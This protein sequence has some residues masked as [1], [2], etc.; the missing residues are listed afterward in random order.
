MRTV[1]LAFFV[2]L[3]ALSNIAY[4]QTQDDALA[5]IDKAG[6]HMQEMLAMNFSVAR[7]NDTLTEANYLFEAQELINRSGGKPDFSLIMKKADEIEQTRKYALNAYDE[8]VA[9]EKMVSGMSGANSTLIE[10]YLAEA[11]DAFANERYEEARSKI[12]ETYEKVSEQQALST[13]LATALEASRKNIVAF[14]GS[15][16]PGLTAGSAAFVVFVLFFGNRVYRV[17]VKRKMGMLDM[18][19][20]VIEGLIRETQKQY[21]DLGKMSEDTYKVHI[22]KFEEMIRDIERRIPL[23]RADL[24]SGKKIFFRLRV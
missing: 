11:K 16:W 12:E 6:Q 20:N 15:N 22:K 3:V 13:K 17:R 18:E 7:I 19:K 1:L 5:A 21:F 24:E 8:L 14:V 23:L 2:S 9:L 4:S 10:S